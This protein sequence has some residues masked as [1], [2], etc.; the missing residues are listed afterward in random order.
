[1]AWVTGILT[2][3]NQGLDAAQ[4]WWYDMQQGPICGGNF[5]QTMQFIVRLI[6]ATLLEKDFYIYALGTW[7]IYLI[8]TVE[9]PPGAY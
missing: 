7:I 2:W 3:L 1:M 8:A 9:L 5:Q 4:Q 6:D